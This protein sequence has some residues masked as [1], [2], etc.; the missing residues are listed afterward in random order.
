MEGL[1][2][3]CGLQSRILSAILSPARKDIELLNIP[4]GHIFAYS[5]YTQLI[6]MM[7]RDGEVGYSVD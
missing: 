4:C 3:F 6:M 2:H 7:L 5:Y 1:C